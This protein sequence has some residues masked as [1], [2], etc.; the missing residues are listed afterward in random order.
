M[1]NDPIVA[2]VRRLRQQHAASFGYDLRRIFED[3]KRSEERRDRDLSPLVTPQER[4]GS[5][6]GP[7]VG[8]VR[9]ARR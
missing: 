8:R 9:F 6:V 2:E 1:K 5:L 7:S 3:L 4:G